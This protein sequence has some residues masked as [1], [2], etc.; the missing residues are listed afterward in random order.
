[1]P[2]VIN[3]DPGNPTNATDIRNVDD[4][5]VSFKGG[6]QERERLGGHIWETSGPS[7][8]ATAGRH[9][10][11][12]E[13]AASST[14]ALDKE[15]YIYGNDGTTKV[16]KFGDVGAAYA[17]L[18]IAGKVRASLG[19]DVTAGGLTIAAGGLTVTAGTI[20]LP[21]GGIPLAALANGAATGKNVATAGSATTGF[22]A[23][24][25][26]VVVA[27]TT[28]SV[29][30][31]VLILTHITII[32][33]V[34]AANI[35]INIQVD[36]NN[37]AVWSTIYTTGQ[38]GVGSAVSNSINI[39]FLD[40]LGTGNGATANYRIQLVHATGTDNYTVRDSSIQVVE[41]R[42]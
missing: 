29:P 12:V 25:A 3:W 23:G 11:G 9:A 37:T 24:Y 42:R 5:I 36:R 13:F 33:N 34:A 39:P 40:A 20:S 21:A 28:G 19:M 31:A 22:G 7:I 41:L 38:T 4:E 32:N 14:G 10:T 6:L 1:M 18:D 35:T 2:P 15:F 30:G 27:L 16:A 8:T 17:G 26:P